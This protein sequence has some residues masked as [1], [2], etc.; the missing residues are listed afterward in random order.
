[1]S[2]LTPEMLMI[3]CVSAGSF[4]LLLS[5]VLSISVLLALRKAARERE[6]VN[7]E[8][9]GLFERIER[10]TSSG[11]EQILK[12]YDGL[13]ESLSQRLPTAV[14]AQASEVIFDTESKILFRLAELDPS[15]N[16]DAESR[17]KMDELIKSME[18]LERTIVDLT[19]DAVRHVMVEGRQSLFPEESKRLD[20]LN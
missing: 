17:R 20:N 15:L 2:A 4:L 10:L 11:R 19:S 9:S 16:K 8:L 7:R 13:L 18:G 14:A 12:H 3:V 1:M 5:I 6:I